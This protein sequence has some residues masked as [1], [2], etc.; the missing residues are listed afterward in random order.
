LL[1]ITASVANAAE[2]WKVDSAILFYS[3]GDGRVSAIEPGVFAST[4]LAED[5]RLSFRVVIDALTGATPNGAH[6]SSVPQTFTTPSGNSSYIVAPG[7]TPLDSTF[8]DT[9]I[10]F[11]VDWE[12]PI[13]RLSRMVY[14]FNL[15]GEHDYISLGLSATYLRDFN[16]RNTT[17]T[18]GLAF[19]NDT[20]NPEGGVPTAF[21][22][23]RSAGINRDGADDTKSIT[24]FII[25]VTQVVSRKTLVQLNFST[26]STS[27]Y[28]NDPYKIVTVV[29]PATG[30]PTT[31]GLLLANA[32]ALPYVYEKRPDSRQRNSLFFKTV[33]HLEEDVIDFS[34]RYFW[35]D[36]DITSHTLDFKYRYEMKGGN[37]LQPHLRYYTQEAANFYTHNLVQG[38]DVDAN[39][40]VL[41]DY[42][43][44]DY[45]LAKSVTS[46]L[47]LKYGVKL[48]DNSELGFRAELIT[49]SVDNNGVPAG[50][51]TPD[52]NAIIVQANYSFLW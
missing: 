27:G 16:N 4:E 12:K 6:A 23:M 51:E 20:I 49:Q 47:G 29:D 40:N 3:E 9:R 19:N 28:Q 10:A 26:G 41:V 1:Q 21:S 38:T 25:G 48:G 37:Y 8:L 46:T 24:D 44:N 52:L 22:P 14:G 35:D 32:D 45:R 43:S 31:S 50:E 18:A 11:G 36:W 13:N 39:G 34:Y 15:S 42:A 7:E 17:L 2:D 5:E 30:L 33:H